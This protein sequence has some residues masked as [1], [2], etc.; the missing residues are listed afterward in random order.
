MATPSGVAA[1]PSSRACSRS[2][3]RLASIGSRAVPLF[4]KNWTAV[5]CFS[6]SVMPA[7]ASAINC[8]RSSGL[9]AFSFS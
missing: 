8:S 2:L 6:L 1:I 9:A 3:V 7:I 4:P 5:A